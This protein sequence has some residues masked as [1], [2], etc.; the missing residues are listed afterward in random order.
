MEFKWNQWNVEHLWKHGVYPAEAEAIVRAARTPFPRSVGGGKYLVW[1]A[2][3][4]GR[5]VQ[6][7]FVIQTDSR[8]FV[9]HA[10]PLTEA[11]K[12]QRNRIKR[13]RGTR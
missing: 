13:R 9:I 10:R 12:R 2:G 1:G 7:I 3:T 5:L 11:E 8:V 6:V 4:G